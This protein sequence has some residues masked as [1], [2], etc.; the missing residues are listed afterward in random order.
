[1]LVLPFAV[2]LG[3]PEILGDAFA[4][5]FTDGLPPT[6][7]PELVWGLEEFDAFRDASA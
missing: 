4:S 7:L 5:G 6:L 1:M 2:G 3:E